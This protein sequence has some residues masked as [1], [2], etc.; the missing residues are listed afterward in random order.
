MKNVNAFFD[1]NILQE[2]FMLIINHIYHKLK[3]NIKN[4]VLYVVQ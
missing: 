2:F 1:K 4:K 3:Q